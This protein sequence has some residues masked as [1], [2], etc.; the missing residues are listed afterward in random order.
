MNPQPNGA[1]SLLGINLGIAKRHV[2]P[3][4]QSQRQNAMEPFSRQ[5]DALSRI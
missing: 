2:L 1:I 4:N 5:K 3:P